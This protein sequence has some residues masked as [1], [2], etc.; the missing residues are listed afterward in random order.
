M[1][2]KIFITMT[3]TVLLAV[4]FS[5]AAGFT[6]K[7]DSIDIR[8]ACQMM[9]RAGRFNVVF[10]KSVRGKT[11][12]SEQNN[13]P[14]LALKKVTKSVGL[15]AI[16][17]KG[18]QASY[19]PHR[20]IKT[21]LVTPKDMPPITLKIKTPPGYGFTLKNRDIDIRDIMQMIARVAKINV[22]FDKNVR[23]RTA[24]EVSRIPPL[25]CLELLCIAQGYKLN[26]FAG[27]PNTYIVAHRAVD[28]LVFDPPID[29]KVPADF[30]IKY[31]D[32]DIRLLLRSIAEHAG[33]RLRIHNSVRGLI[34]CELK[35]MRPLEVLKM[36]AAS[37]Y[38][39]V[40]A[41]KG[42]DKLYEVSL[43]Q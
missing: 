4:E 23:G 24:V 16:E 3:L 36:V 20:E 42:E 9:A 18:T 37:N 12:V 2:Y 22:I 8:D 29:A 11:A 21:F 26:R 41:V 15:H 6:L 1:N 7:T 13:D 39:D 10:H 40:K 43:S 25:R 31:R 32:S 19:P 27:A 33:I 35:H 38:L 14:V 30:T 28:Q 17:V 34:A 5:F